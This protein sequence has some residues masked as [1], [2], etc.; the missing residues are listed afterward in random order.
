MKLI[1]NICLTGCLLGLASW[2]LAKATEAW[3]RVVGSAPKGSETKIPQQVE[4]AYYDTHRG[5][6]LVLARQQLADGW[7][8]E[9]VNEYFHALGVDMFVIN[10][11]NCQLKRETAAKPQTEGGTNAN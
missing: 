2:T 5:E 3:L 10:W 7:T 4:G 6:A 11:I 8:T 9:G 1:I